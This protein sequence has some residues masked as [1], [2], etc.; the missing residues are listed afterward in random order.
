[1]SYTEDFKEPIELIFSEKLLSG[2]NTSK[3]TSK[4]NIID[5]FF[6]GETWSISHL[7]DNEV[8][9]FRFHSDYDKSEIKIDNLLNTFNEKLEKKY[10]MYR[11][12]KIKKE[13]SAFDDFFFSIFDEV[14]NH[15]RIIAIHRAIY[16]I[17]ENSLLEK[18]FSIYK[19]GLLP[20][21]FKS[22]IFY[23]FNPIILK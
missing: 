16:G 5:D 21:K 14:Y 18:V 22:D 9:K 7:I 23:T 10:F 2:N 20:Y 6:S 17:N 8:S 3:K 19:D 4:N 11:K 1:M 12:S 13:N 15:L